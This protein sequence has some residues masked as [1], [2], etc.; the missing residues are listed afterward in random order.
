MIHRILTLHTSYT[1][2]LFQQLTIILRST[3]N[4]KS[5]MNNMFQENKKWNHR[6][7]YC[8]DDPAFLPSSSR[9]RNQHTAS[10]Q[11]ASLSENCLYKI[12]IHF[13][14]YKIL[15][16]SW[17]WAA[18]LFLASLVLGCKVPWTN[19]LLSCTNTRRAHDSSHL[20]KDKLLWNCTPDM[21]FLIAAK[22]T[23]WLA[24]TEKSSSI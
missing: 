24:A 21:K 17:E 3:E 7:C 5:H 22:P 20:D 2:G 13:Q 6:H 14:P 10:D 19:L 1:T 18:L 9:H 4:T 23:K 16:T 15:K 12:M 11:V 8:H